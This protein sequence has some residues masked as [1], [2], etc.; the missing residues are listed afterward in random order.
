[1][2][3]TR[4]LLSGSLASWARILV[5]MVT[6]LALV[7]IYLA[8]WTVETY[9]IWIT[10]QAITL[11]ITTLDKGHVDYLGYEFL[12]LGSHRKDDI[13]RRL[14][15]GIDVLLLV[16]VAELTLLALVLFSFPV[17]EQVNYHHAI[18]PELVNQTKWVLLISCSG[19]LFLG[20]S[21][22]L[23]FRALSVYGYFP[24][25]CWWDLLNAIVSTLATVVAVLLGGNLL[26]VGI[27]FTISQLCVVL[28]EYID[29]RHLLKKHGLAI[30][31]A[32][33]RYGFANYVTSLTLAGRYFLE[34]FRQQGI[35]L[36]LAPL[37]GVAGLAAFSTMRT[38]SNVALQGLSTLVN[39]LMPE[40]MRFVALREQ[41]KM[42]AAFSTIWFVVVA[43]LAPG[44]VGLQFVVKP[45]F[46]NWTTH[47]IVFNPLLF[48]L[49]S[50][51]ILVYAIAQPAMAILIGNNL[52]KAQL[53]IFGAVAGMVLVSMVALVPFVGVV[54]A[55]YALLSGELML[56]LLAQKQA[57]NWLETNGLAWPRK[58]FTRASVSVLIAAIGMIGMVLIPA[59]KDLITILTFVALLVNIRLYIRQLSDVAIH[60]I[61][62]VLMRFPSIQ[63][64]YSMVLTK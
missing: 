32:D 38:V 36:V 56:A 5:T 34:S 8:H 63:K 53:R 51:S 35:R 27:V 57:Q 60:K 30:Q 18:Q 61:N 52:L 50:L 55:G 45:L 37:V 12:K 9:G 6:Q 33:L 23:F 21:T 48:A 28:I 10:V 7:P 20:N 62:A 47:K 43:L 31:K 11:V 16:G 3:T 1:M 41:K 29:I 40:I 25:M 54:G 59:G 17:V 4:R 26:T 44:I 39:P 24:R 15:S 42:E 22:G 46:A 64:V 14:W 19:V 49:L 13:R 2:S 58:E